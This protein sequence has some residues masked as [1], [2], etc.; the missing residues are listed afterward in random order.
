VT[1][2]NES[3]AGVEVS[4]AEYAITDSRGKPPLRRW[5]DRRLNGAEVEHFATMETAR[6]IGVSSSDILGKKCTVALARG[7]K[8]AIEETWRKSFDLVEDKRVGQT[9]ALSTKVTE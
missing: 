1:L 9:D 8:S 6:D 2:L 5:K 7:L 4:D 3:E